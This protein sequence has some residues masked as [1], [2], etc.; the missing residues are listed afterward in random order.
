MGRI[1]S[2]NVKSL[3]QD[4]IKADASKY[5]DNFQTNKEIISA[6]VQTTSKKHRNIIAGYMT[7][8]VGRI[9]KQGA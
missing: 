3:V 9:K 7:R 5:S 4:L 1:K 6:S 8:L 2:K